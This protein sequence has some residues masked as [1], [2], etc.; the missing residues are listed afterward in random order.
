MNN[1]NQN[2]PGPEQAL[3]EFKLLAYKIGLKS[4]ELIFDGKPL[5]AP[6]ARENLTADFD[7]ICAR[8]GCTFKQMWDL[9][10]DKGA[11]FTEEALLRDLEN[12]HTENPEDPQP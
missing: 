3:R 10:L 8:H 2:L 9:W 11:F 1:D 5:D 12:F 6:K 7:D 4:I